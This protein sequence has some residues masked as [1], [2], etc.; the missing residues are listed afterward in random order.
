[1]VIQGAKA[2]AIP[3]VLGQELKFSHNARRKAKIVNWVSS[4]HG[5]VTWYSN[6][7]NIE[8]NFEPS[9]QG[10]SE[11]TEFI[12][13]LL[14]AID[15][16]NP[17]FFKEQGVYTFKTFMDFDPG[18]GLGSSSSLIANL[19]MVA[20]I[21]PFDLLFR[22][23]LNQGSGYDVAVCFMG[24]PLT[25]HIEEEVYHWAEPTEL[26]W[27]DFAGKCRLVYLNRKQDSN[28]EVKRFKSKWKVGH[29]HDTMKEISEISEKLPSV[30]DY[31]EFCNLLAQHEL[32]MSEV[33]KQKCI[34]EELFPDFDGV[35]K[36]LGAWGGDFI[37]ACP[38]N[39]PKLTEQYFLNKGYNVIIDFK[40]M[41]DYEWKN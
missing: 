6:Q 37:L 2:L 21:Q 33:L 14:F 18:W 3:T 39:N 8:N 17:D 4:I 38:K 15:E 40:K 24:Q 20:E 25:Y 29:N 12:R 7:F 31:D 16:L 13:S 30:T 1:M 28:L 11:R 10:S 41:I 27:N 36:S 34:K 23:S 19:A 9:T 35:I 22:S 26:A 32:I 5:G